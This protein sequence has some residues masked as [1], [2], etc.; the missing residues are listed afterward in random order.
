[1]FS[2]GLGFLHGVHVTIS[3]IVKI[4]PLFT[5]I[6]INEPMIN[7]AIFRYKNNIGGCLI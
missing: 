2:F 3:E 1:L 4:I 7:D 5:N 6:T